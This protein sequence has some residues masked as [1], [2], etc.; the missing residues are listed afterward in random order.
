MIRLFNQEQYLYCV[1]KRL[2]KS[3]RVAL[4]NSIVCSFRV[5]FVKAQV[6][7]FTDV[8]NGSAVFTVR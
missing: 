6:N 5:L 7:R 8:P 1:T 3:E 4:G 2:T